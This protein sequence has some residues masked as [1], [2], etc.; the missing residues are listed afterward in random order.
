MAE[1]T[2][3]R[4]QDGEGFTADERAAMKERAKEVRRGKKK[5]GLDDLLEK[6]AEMQDSD[7]EIAERVHALVNEHAPEL[8]P[9]TWYG[10]PAYAKG[11]KV[12]LFFQSA[13]KFNGRYATLGFQDTAQL[14]DGEM[15]ATS[16]AITG[17]SAATE[18]RIVELVTRAV[19]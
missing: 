16:Y 6:V 11:G 14:D 12:L 2:R 3:S 7:R 5:N 17:L 4:E 1:R 18:Q 9:K 8:E 10:M 19:G 15:W 13:E